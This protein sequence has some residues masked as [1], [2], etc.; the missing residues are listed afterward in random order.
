MVHDSGGGFVYRSDEE[1]LA[2]LKEIA[3]SPERRSELGQKGYESFVR[4]WCREAHLDLYF[5]YLNR[6]AEKKFGQAP[7]LR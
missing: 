2:A 1:L 6:S 5:G 7:W 3:V 4:L